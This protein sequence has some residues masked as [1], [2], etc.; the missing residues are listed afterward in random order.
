[1]KDLFFKLALV[2]LMSA[3]T[4]G[5][6]RDDDPSGASSS[7]SPA[8]APQSQADRD[9]VLATVNDVEIT[10]EDLQRQINAQSPYLR[11]RY[12][13]LDKQKEFLQSMVRFEILAQEA[14]RRGLDRD[15]DVIRTMK[16]VMIQ[17]LMKAQFD[18]GELTPGKIP[19]DELRA[20]YE[21][22][23]DEYERPEQVR[24]SAIIMSDAGRAEKVARLAKGEAGASV[25]GFRELVTEHSVD[26]AT[27]KRGGDLSYIARGDTELPE[28]VAQAAFAL[29]RSG[30]VEGPI[31]AGDRFY[32]IKQTGKKKGISKDFEDVK[33][34]IQNRL[35]R[36][37]RAAAQREFIDDLRAKAEVEIDQQ[38]FEKIRIDTSPPTVS[39]E[40]EGHQH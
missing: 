8:A 6:K 4:L 2:A 26:E 28:P 12:K 9:S 14:A 5:C 38:A 25:K 19:E 22:H 15:P 33:G 27:R 37:K 31:A 18:G 23:Q 32:I 35:Y 34:S 29:Q 3:A 13:S 10:V 24:L 40:T 17:K 30:Q 16:Q 11:P 36:E 39:Q 1:M 20:Y 7:A 21:E